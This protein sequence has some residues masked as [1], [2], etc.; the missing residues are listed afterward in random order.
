M[1][2]TVVTPPSLETTQI[3]TAPLSAAPVPVP[4]DTSA[5]TPSAETGAVATANISSGDG[6]GINFIRDQRKRLDAHLD[7]DKKIAKAT[8]IILVVFMLVFVAAIGV[9]FYFVSQQDKI[10]TATDQATA[11]LSSLSSLEKE[12]LV[13]AKK[14]KL[15]F[16]IDKDREIKRAAS[17][18]FFALIPSED[19]LK[20]MKTDDATQINTIVFSIETPDVFAVLRLLKSFAAKSVYDQGYVLQTEKLAR[21]VD[22]IYSISGTMNYSKASALAKSGTKK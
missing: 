20:S 19:L 9:S 15:L 8:M 22:G 1:A 17:A 21:R 13:Y 2:E 7:G 14:L 18:F 5:Q 4:A 11:H 6:M 3:A 16:A 10:K 12:Y